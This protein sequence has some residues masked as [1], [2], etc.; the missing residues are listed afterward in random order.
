MAVGD[1]VNGI[2]LANT[3]FSFQPAAGVECVITTTGAVS[4]W[5]FLSNGVT[6]AHA[7]AINSSTNSVGSSNCKFCINNTNYLIV[8]AAGATY[9]S[10]YTGIQI[11]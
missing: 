1:V 10:N 7:F 11:K 8:Q 2:G 3:D 4:A 5:I 6:N 9:Y